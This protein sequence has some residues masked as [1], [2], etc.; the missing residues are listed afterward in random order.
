MN[1]A[2]ILLEYNSTYMLCKRQEDVPLGGYWSVPGGSIESGENSAEAAIRELYEETQIKVSIYDIE[3][4]DVFPTVQRGRDFYLYHSTIQRYI[5]PVLD[6]EHTDWGWFSED[7][8]P[9]PIQDNLKKIISPKYNFSES[10]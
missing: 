7:E 2:G 6:F 3:L 10:G 8:L 4:V 5:E 1:Y 9:S